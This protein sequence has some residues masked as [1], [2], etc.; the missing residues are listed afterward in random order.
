MAGK[1]MEETIGD[2]SAVAPPETASDASQVESLNQTVD[3]TFIKVD[4]VQL[5]W[6]LSN[7]DQSI[8]LCIIL[9]LLNFRNVAVW[10]F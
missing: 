8:S 1:L 7:V 4:Q 3:E 10:I 2:A 6:S 5:F 9:L